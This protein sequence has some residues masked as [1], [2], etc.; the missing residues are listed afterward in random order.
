MPHNTLT[1]SPASFDTLDLKTRLDRRQKSEQDLIAIFEYRRIVWISLEIDQMYQCISQWKCR[2]TFPIYSPEISSL[3]CWSPSRWP[4]ISLLQRSIK[5][6]GKCSRNYM[7]KHKYI[8]LYSN[9]FF[10]VL[11]TKQINALLTRGLVS[12]EH[13]TVRIR[14]MRAQSKIWIKKKLCELWCG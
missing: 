1:F 13:E 14:N 8:L 2:A 9:R 10:D 5:V 3:S 4:K 12:K 6:A 11:R 7:N